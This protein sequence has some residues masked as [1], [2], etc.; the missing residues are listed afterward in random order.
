MQPVDE[1]ALRTAPAPEDFGEP[2]EAVPWVNGV[3]LIELSRVVERP[4]AAREGHPEIA[5][6]YRGLPGSVALGPGSVLLGSCA[7]DRAAL[8]LDE[9]QLTV[10]CCECGERGCWPL[11]ARL[12]VDS[13]LVVW[14]DFEQP[15][16]F[17]WDLSALGPFVF[18]R[19]QYEA[20]VTAASDSPAPS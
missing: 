12:E 1:L 13:D 10:L 18:D 14:R 9:G 16:R 4:F 19:R 8:Y 2:L 17:E 15:H 11:T 6:G 5:G 7:T 3:S 20:A